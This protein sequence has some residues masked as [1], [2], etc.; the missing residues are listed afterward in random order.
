MYTAILQSET[1]ALTQTQR[2]DL[3]T[4]T[5]SKNSFDLVV[6]PELFMS[7][8]NAGDHL[9]LC[10]EHT[11]GP[12]FQK[13]AGLAKET[14][15][16]IV[17][18]YPETEDD[19]LFNAAM[20][21]N[22]EGVRIANHRKLLIPPGFEQ[23]YFNCG[24]HFTVFDLMDFRCALLVCYDAEFPET[25]RAAAQAGAQLVI[26]PTALGEQW[27]SVA[28]QMMPTRSFENGVWLMY[29]NH[30][31]VE[32]GLRYLGAS[33]IVAPDGK[34][35]ARADSHQQLIAAEIDIA[36]AINA[37][38]RLPYLVDLRRFEGIS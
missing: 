37:Q 3:L 18:G 28:H 10:A 1:G 32:N 12:F 6:C 36:S 17:Y 8:Y 22:A 14:S 11:D 4:D 27:P 19:Q 15:T 26:V 34:D 24:Q 31:G 23:D 9:R 35:A 16:A 21:I 5:V 2:L 25:V 38:K 7:G 20:C 29:A 30:A 13:A 33:C